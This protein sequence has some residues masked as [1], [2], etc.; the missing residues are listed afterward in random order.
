MS[1][2]H[3]WEV[4]FYASET[5]GWDDV[6]DS[7]AEATL[8][9]R[10]REATERLRSIF[11]EFCEAGAT[12]R[13]PNEPLYCGGPVPNY[14]TD[15]EPIRS[16]T[17]NGDLLVVETEQLHQMRMR[18]RYTLVPVNGNWKIRDNRVGLGFQ[19]KRWKPVDL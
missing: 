11:A 17:A 5:A 19:A 2:M 15:Q 6:V 8:D 13:R 14:D 10:R 9:A 12:A 18:F 7:E 3:E 1:R 4:Q 16:V